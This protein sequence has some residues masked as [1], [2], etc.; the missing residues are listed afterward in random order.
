[1]FLGGWG[2]Y[3]HSKES[4]VLLRIVGFRIIGMNFATRALF[5][6]V[7]EELSLFLGPFFICMF[8]RI[9]SRLGI[10]LLFKVGPAPLG[11]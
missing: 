3:G 10:P 5:A 11:K 9:V 2:W 7:F 4:V 8:K 6:S 1:M